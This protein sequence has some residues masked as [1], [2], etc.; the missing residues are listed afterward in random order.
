MP[1]IDELMSLDPLSLTKDGPE[2]RAIIA[3]YRNNRAKEGADGK[4]PRG[5][6]RS[7]PGEKMKLD[8]TELLQSMGSKGPSP[9][10][11]SAPRPS[12]GLRKL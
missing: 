8:L 6:S 4:M 1:E 12:G 3:Y 11:A 10:S 9:A 7:A 5:K 2:L